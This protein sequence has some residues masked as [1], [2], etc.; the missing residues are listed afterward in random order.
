MHLRK[1]SVVF[2]VWRAGSFA[3]AG[4]ILLYSRISRLL[5]L[6]GPWDLVNPIASARFIG[7]FAGAACLLGFW[8][9]EIVVVYIEAV[10]KA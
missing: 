1:L 7:P 8:D 6:Q 3:F 9:V 2:A 10:F 4:T 5:L